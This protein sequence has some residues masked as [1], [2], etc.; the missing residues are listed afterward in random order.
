M[1]CN[2]WMPTEK[3]RRGPAL[4]CLQCLL[5]MNYVGIYILKQIKR[6]RFAQGIVC[7]MRVYVCAR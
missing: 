3:E 6:G 7:I 1:C 2:V 4:V 5:L